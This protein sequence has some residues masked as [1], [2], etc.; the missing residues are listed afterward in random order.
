MKTK[1]LLFNLLLLIVSC[2]AQTTYPLIT[3]IGSISNNS[4][5]KDID[6]EYNQFVGTWKANYDNKEITLK[7]TKVIKKPFTDSN[8]SY[9]SD[10]L[11][12]QHLIK[13][14]IGNIIENYISSNL[15]NNKIIS[16]L[17]SK[18]TSQARLNYSG[19]YCHLGSGV[20]RL[21]MQDSTHFIWNYEPMDMMIVKQS[22]PDYMNENT[23]INLPMVEN[24]IF[25]KQ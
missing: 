16:I 6:N 14:N 1:I 11:I 18:R 25:T 13:D 21:K 7:I 17:Y 4:Y 22:C 24:L 10:V 8:K 9:Y 12:V 19:I 3:E 15:D 2:K 23:K 20:I 5:I